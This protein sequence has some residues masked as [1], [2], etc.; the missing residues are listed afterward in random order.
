MTCWVPEPLFCPL[1]KRRPFRPQFWKN[2]FREHLWS[3]KGYS[4]DYF[5]AQFQVSR[6]ISSPF[7]RLWLTVCLIFVAT[8]LVICQKWRPFRTQ[9]W[10]KNFWEHFRSQKGYSRDYFEPKF[11]SLGPLVSILQVFFVQKRAFLCQKRQF[12][13]P[14]DALFA[15]FVVKKLILRLSIT[16]SSIIAGKQILKS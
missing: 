11:R 1:S 3:P 16:F 8:F 9:F 15:N 13:K 6:A 12:L 2:N 4:R 7:T 5:Q 14:L 10:K